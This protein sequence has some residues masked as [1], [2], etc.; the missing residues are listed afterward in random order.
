MSTHLR[1]LWALA[2]IA[3]CLAVLTLYTN[4]EIALT[5]ASQLWACF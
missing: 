1:A 3:A 4:P 5:L 2:A